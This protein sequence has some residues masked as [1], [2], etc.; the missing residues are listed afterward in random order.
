[1][2][3]SAA[4]KTALRKLASVDNLTWHSAYGLGISL[5]TLHALTKKGLVARKALLGHMFSP[6]TGIEFKV[7]PAAL[8]EASVASKLPDKPDYEWAEDFM[9]EAYKGL[10]C[11]EQ[12]P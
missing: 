3:L 1:M 12:K 10:V 5:A 4:Q 8:A 6:R 2:L 11:D 9:C 7:T